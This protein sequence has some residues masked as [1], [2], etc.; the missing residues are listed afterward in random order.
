[1]SIDRL[2]M[3]FCPYSFGLLREGQPQAFCILEIEMI[4]IDKSQLTHQNYVIG[5]SDGTVK[6][7]TTGRGGERIK[8]VIKKKVRGSNLGVMALSLSD[9]RTRKEAYRIERDTCY[10]LR[11]CVVNGTREWFTGKYEYI[12]QTAGMFSACGLTRK[13][14]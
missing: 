8:E 7:G 10:L 6:V 4:D 12:K 1:M 13:S 11:F 14:S 9:I 2:R 5:F 3:T